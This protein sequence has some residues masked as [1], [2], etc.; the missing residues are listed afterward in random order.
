MFPLGYWHFGWGSLPLPAYLGDSTWKPSCKNMWFA[1]DYLLDEEYSSKSS[2]NCF[3]KI[4]SHDTISWWA[5]MEEGTAQRT[6]RKSA[7]K[8]TRWTRSSTSCRSPPRGAPEASS[9]DPTRCLHRRRWT[10]WSP[11][12]PCSCQRACGG[13]P[14]PNPRSPCQS[15]FERT[16]SSWCL[17]IEIAYY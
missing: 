17:H 4:F 2:L 10:P 3:I 12:G 13:G 11:G 16:T 1:V 8:T 15:Y 9:R 7:G 14:T 5:A 6:P